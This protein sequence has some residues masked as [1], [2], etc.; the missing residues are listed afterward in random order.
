VAYEELCRSERVQVGVVGGGVWRCRLERECGYKGW[1][2]NG[3]KY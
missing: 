1:F 3:Y 2:G